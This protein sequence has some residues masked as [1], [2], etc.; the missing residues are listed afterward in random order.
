MLTS[1]SFAEVAHHVRLDIG[2][3]YLAF[4]DALCHPHA[5]VPGARADIG[6]KRSALQRQGVQKLLRLLPGVA[7]RIIELFGPFRRIFELMIEGPIGWTVHLMART[8]VLHGHPEQ[9]KSLACSV[10]LH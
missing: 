8:R 7:F 10:R 3:K 9:R 5:E 2:G 6:D 1:R 4:R